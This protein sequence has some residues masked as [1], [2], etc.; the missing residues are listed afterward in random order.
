MARDFK[1]P[2]SRAGSYV[3]DV[4]G[5]CGIGD[6]GVEGVFEMLLPHVMLA[7]E[8]GGGREVT[9]EHVGVCHL[10]F[11]ESLVGESRKLGLVREISGFYRW[12][13]QKYGEL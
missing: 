3:G 12:R 2:D 7:V 4:C 6:G 13:F 1:E 5:R 10:S 9:A 8:A 11:L